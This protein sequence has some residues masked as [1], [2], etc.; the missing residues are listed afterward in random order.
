M[1]KPLRCVD[2]LKWLGAVDFDD[3]GVPSWCDE[4]LMDP[5]CFTCKITKHSHKEDEDKAAMEAVF[6]FAP[7]RK[8]PITLALVVAAILWAAIACGV[9][10]G[11]RMIKQFIQ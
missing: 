8:F 4:C 3:D 11:W 7:V 2:C 9:V 10:L 5:I 6:A 1:T